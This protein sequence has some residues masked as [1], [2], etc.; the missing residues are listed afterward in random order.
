MC[1]SHRGFFR[2]RQS[3]QGSKGGKELVSEADGFVTIHETSCLLTCSRSNRNQRLSAQVM[4]LAGSLLSEGS[5]GSSYSRNRMISQV[6]M[7][8]ESGE[9]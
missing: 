1:R 5:S 7:D 4:P 6:L 9:I 2:H 8:A 3:H